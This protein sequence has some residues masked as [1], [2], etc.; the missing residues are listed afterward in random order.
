[1][2]YASAEALLW[3]YH[4]LRCKWP[5]VLHVKPTTMPAMLWFLAS[6]L[7]HSCWHGDS[8]APYPPER[9]VLLLS[10]IRRLD[11][12]PGLLS[13]CCRAKAK[14]L[15][16]HKAFDGMKRV[17]AA[18]R[19]QCAAPFCAAALLEPTFHYVCCNDHCCCMRH[20]MLLHATTSLRSL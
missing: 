14:E 16:Q 9:S 18:G 13:V 5:A 7:L 8:S 1:M 4:R 3:M 17:G 12:L 20:H 11:L 6:S 19:A 10:L 2:K 15:N